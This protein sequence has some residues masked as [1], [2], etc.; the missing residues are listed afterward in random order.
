MI[1]AIQHNCARS[2]EGTI[3][4]LETGVE[5]RVDVV[6]LQE[7][8]RERKGFEIMHKADERRKRKRV[9]MAVRKGSGLAVDERTDLSKG[10][11]D[12]VIVTDV[13]RRGEKV[14]RIVNIYDQ[15][16]T[17]S[18]ERPA[19]KLRWQRIIR[20][21]CT[22]LAGDLNA[23]SKR[24]D[25][26]CTEQR[27]AVFLE[28]ILDENGLEIGNDD[29]ATHYWKRE[30]LEGKSII[31][32]TLPNRPIGKCTILAEH[33]ATGSDHEVIEWEVDVETQ[34]EADHER[35]VG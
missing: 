35:V 29:R 22:V 9:W 8:P 11:N 33:H 17:Q 34:E 14:T 13:R 7:P 32:L 4:A 26:R 23:H 1:R 15:K 27:D 10:G 5:R 28:D 20:Q 3:A 2:Y 6:C 30:D 31:D 25:P 24:W 16:D 12:D 18:R 21:G 19:R